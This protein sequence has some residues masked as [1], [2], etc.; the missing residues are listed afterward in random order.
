M[1][2]NPCFQVSPWLNERCR[3]TGPCKLRAEITSDCRHVD[4]GSG[5]S[6]TVIR[7]IV[8]KGSDLFLSPTG[9]M[10]TMYGGGHVAQN[11][12][13][14]TPRFKDFLFQLGFK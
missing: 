4:V 3:V 1:L 9:F 7:L 10:A 6:A 8:M 2:L 12:R 5:L 11:N 14:L 13:T